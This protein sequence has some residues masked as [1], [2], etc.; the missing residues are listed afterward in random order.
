MKSSG[1]SSTGQSPLFPQPSGQI[2]TEPITVATVPLNNSANGPCNSA[3]QQQQ[4]QQQQQQ[5]T[6]PN[7][8]AQSTRPAVAMDPKV[9]AELMHLRAVIKEKDRRLDE[10]H[11]EVDKLSSVLQQHISE[12]AT[13]KQV[14]SFL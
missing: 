8:Q 13:W 1:T 12:C 6:P 9:T 5:N 11:S 10:L 3:Q 4:K 14:G 7:S 2:H